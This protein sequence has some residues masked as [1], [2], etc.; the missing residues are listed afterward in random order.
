MKL[1]DVESVPHFFHDERRNFGPN[2][3]P[4]MLVPNQLLFGVVG[5]DDLTNSV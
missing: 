5:F 1:F 3:T 2:L 4:L